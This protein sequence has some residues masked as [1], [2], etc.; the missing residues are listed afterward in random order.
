[1]AFS[2]FY[3]LICFCVYFYSGQYTSSVRFAPD[4]SETKEGFPSTPPRTP[5]REAIARMTGTPGS[6][7]RLRNVL[8]SRGSEHSR[9][10]TLGNNTRLVFV[11]D[12]IVLQK[13][14]FCVC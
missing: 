11:S 8:A 5:A 3:V 10:N 9:R 14:S 7:N 12:I 1:M 4:Q 13:C 2:H 6:M